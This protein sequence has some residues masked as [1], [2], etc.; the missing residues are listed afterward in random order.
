[1]GGVPVYQRNTLSVKAVLSANA[2]SKIKANAGANA[3][4]A[5]EMG[6]RFN[7]ATGGWNPIP[8][9]PSFE[10]SFKAG[11]DVKGDVHGEV[12][13]IPNLQVEF[14]RVVAADLSVEPF[15][16]GD[17]G[18]ASIPKGELL[19][20]FGYA[21]I[22]L[23]KFDINLQAQAFIGVSVGIFSKKFPVLGKTQV[24][25]SPQWLKPLLGCLWVF[26]VRNSRC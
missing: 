12:R 2:S 6:A 9:T 17:I 16:T 10:K 3:T 7:P 20:E 25:E 15:I 13:L 8:P 19:V 1:V 21:P 24:W 14:Y 26:S 18:V 23:T 4:A 22:Q 5:I 11:L